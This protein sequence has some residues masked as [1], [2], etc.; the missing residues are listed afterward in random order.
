MLARSDPRHRD[1]AASSGSGTIVKT[2]VVA[3][4]DRAVADAL[5]GAAG[6]EVILTHV[7]NNWGALSGGR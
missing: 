6:E 4:G 7:R 2:P 3:I 5:A 1:N